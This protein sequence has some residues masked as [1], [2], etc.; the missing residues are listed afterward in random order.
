MNWLSDSQFIILVFV[1]RLSL[2]RS[3]NIIDWLYS[4]PATSIFR[5]F[6]VSCADLLETPLLWIIATGTQYGTA[7]FLTAAA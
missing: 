7:E 3:G 6:Q 1:I 2:P 5:S 4:T